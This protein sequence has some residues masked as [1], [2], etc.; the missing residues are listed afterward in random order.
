MTGKLTAFPVSTRADRSINPTPKTSSFIQNVESL[1]A[2]TEYRRCDKGEDLEDIYRLR[3]KAYRSNDMVPD[4]ESSSIHDDL[5]ETPNAFRFGVYVDQ[6]LVSTLRVHHVTEEMPWS[7]STKAFGDLVYPM[8]AAG[9]T[10]VC[11]GRFA[12]DPDWT[13]VYPHLPFV[14]LRIATMACF[15]FDVPYGLSTV[16]EDHSGFYKRMYPSE[17]ISEPRAYPGVFNRVVLHRINT[18][19]NQEQYFARFPFFKSTPM[20]RRMLFARPVVGE[21]APLTILPTAK[22]LREAA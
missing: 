11:P 21:L 20:E 14:T 6:Q 5:D 10:F 3:Y 12:S 8:L 17:R 13:R 4:S 16:R 19:D 22:Y 18:R 2:R 7:P 1:L 9:D 15:H